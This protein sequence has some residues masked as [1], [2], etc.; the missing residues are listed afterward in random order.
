MEG[1][2]ILCQIYSC[3]WR[4]RFPQKKTGDSAKLIRNG[5]DPQST[6]E[7]CAAKA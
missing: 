4:S 7:S 6:Q 2:K 5:H 1:Q 3:E